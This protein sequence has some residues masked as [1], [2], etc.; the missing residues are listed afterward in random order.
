MT[1]KERENF[2]RNAIL[3]AD[4]A[5][6]SV[7]CF[8]DLDLKNKHLTFE[9]FLN[10]NQHEIYHLCYNSRCC[11]C[12][13]GHTPPRGGSRVLYPSQLDI[14]YDKSLKRTNHTHGRSPDFCCSL[15]KTGIVTSIL[16]L[17]LGRCLLVNFC[18]DVFWYSCL[19]IQSLTLEHFLNQNKHI[20]YHLWQ[21]NSSCCQCQPNAFISS[22]QQI[23]DQRQWATLYTANV[24]PSPVHRKRPNTGIPTSICAFA[25]NSGIKV[26]ILDPHVNKIIIDNCCVVRKTVEL[27][28]QRRNHVYGHANEAKIS[29]SDYLQY[30]N[31]IGN[32]LIEI[33]RVCG[34]ES[35]VRQQLLDLQKRTLD[36]AL[37]IQYQI[38]MLDHVSR[39]EALNNTQNKHLRKTVEK[40][41]TVKLPK[42]LKKSV[43]SMK[44]RLGLVEKSS[45]ETKMVVKRIETKQA[46]HTRKEI[47]QRIK[48]K[49]FVETRAVKKFMTLHS[50]KYVFL[51]T[52]SAGKGKSRNGLDIL[53]QLGEKYPTYDV[54]KVS[55]LHSVEKILNNDS[56]TIFLLEDV[57][58]AIS[59]DVI[60]KENVLQLFMDSN[61]KKIRVS[62]LLLEACR[63]VNCKFVTW[64]LKNIDNESLKVT[65]SFN[66][67]CSY[68]RLQIIKI[69]IQYVDHKL[70]NFTSAFLKSVKEE[71]RQHNDKNEKVLKFLLNAIDHSLFDLNKIAIK[72]IILGQEDVMKI[73]LNNVD[74]QSFETEQVVDYACEQGLLGIVEIFWKSEN[75]EQINVLSTVNRALKGKQTRRCKLVQRT[76]QCWDYERTCPIKFTNNK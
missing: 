60:H 30:T 4:H 33:A 25:A 39:N 29:D 16:D 13:R 56:R 21:N 38:I 45:K 31:E 6:D 3:I 58:E 34:N 5:K 46:N 47:D 57:F 62:L 76:Y 23:L 9:Q 71:W 72:T 22:S 41:V 36:E 63:G 55:D 40:A 17:T 49:T 59:N 10:Q 68:G 8:V 28:V 66:E 74:I 51:I 61:I 24:L 52:G 48:E 35:E 18:T 67:S 14:L 64:L 50:D 65:S 27:I 2:L 54:V 26:Q 20:L 12:P 73:L 37:F 42:V 43:T 32:G 75:K 7:I 70:L 53:R 44:D 1:Q 15:A 11:Q 69:M 19:T